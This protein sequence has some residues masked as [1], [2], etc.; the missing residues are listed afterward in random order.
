MAKEYMYDRYLREVFKVSDDVYEGTI[1]EEF[2]N[3][4]SLSTF[5]IPVDGRSMDA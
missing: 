2:F 1:V 5:R 3:R 4:G